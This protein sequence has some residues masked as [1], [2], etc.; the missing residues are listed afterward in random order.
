MVELA[1]DV[2]EPLGEASQFTSGGKIFQLRFSLG[3]VVQGVRK[4]RNKRENPFGTNSP[5]LQ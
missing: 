3:M 1:A 2:Q 4:K 5:F